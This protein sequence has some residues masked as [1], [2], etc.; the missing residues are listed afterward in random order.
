MKL[1]LITKKI[2]F[3]ICAAAF[4]LIATAFLISLFIPPV[5]VPDALIFS[6]GAALMTALNILK[7]ILLE[8]TVSKISNM[9]DPNTGKA[10]ALIQYSL[11]YF[12]T[13]IVAAAAIYIM[14]LITEESPFISIGTGMSRTY[15]P[16]VLGL[17]IGLF[18]MKIGVVAA[19]F[20]KHENDTQSVA[21]EDSGTDDKP[22]P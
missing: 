12:L 5:S 20:S 13:V 6:A 10:Y 9:D 21:S 19:G 15:A 11:R 16:L 4:I 7:V 14:Y 2:I 22:D 8:R 18:T 1:S 3:R 17:V